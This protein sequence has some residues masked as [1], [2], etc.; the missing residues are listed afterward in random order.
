MMDDGCLI[1][2][3]KNTN[4]TSCC[5]IMMNSHFIHKASEM[6]RREK[7]KVDVI[8]TTLMK[9]QEEEE[10]WKKW[11]AWRKMMRLMAHLH[12]ERLNAFA[13]RCFSC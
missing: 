6:P 11:F 13:F 3:N 9:E 5:D 1:H 7:I 8:I 4:I 2:T 12:L 10:G